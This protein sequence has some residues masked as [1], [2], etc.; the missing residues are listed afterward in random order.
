MTMYEA[1]KLIMEQ[2]QAGTRQRKTRDRWDIETNY[3]Y[4]W[5]AE[6]C[7]YTLA[8]AKARLAEYRE[9]ACGRYI[10]RMTKHREAITKEV[11]A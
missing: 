6:D 11:Q 9:N 1:E 7:E 4:G 10:V 5:E 8:A 3:G 2:E